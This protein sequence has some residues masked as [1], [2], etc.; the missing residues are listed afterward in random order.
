M[1][2]V[3]SSFR[4]YIY[5]SCTYIYIWDLEGCRISMVNTLNAYIS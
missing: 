2:L 5:A 4:V 1:F 3:S